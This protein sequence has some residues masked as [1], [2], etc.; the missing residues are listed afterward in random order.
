MPLTLYCKQL[1]K[2][3]CVS[4]PNN[5]MKELSLKL[6]LGIPI[7]MTPVSGKRIKASD[8]VE[9][10]YVNDA[11]F[12]CNWVLKDGRWHIYNKVERT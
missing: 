11:F 10:R 12:C 4:L 5:E 8:R 9:N 3:I 1:L 7:H 6:K 2:N